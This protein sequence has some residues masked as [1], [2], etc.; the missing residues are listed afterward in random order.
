[1]SRERDNDGRRGLRLADLVRDRLA[2]VVRRELDDP[3]LSLLVVTQVKVSE[4][5]SFVDVG[6]SFLG[7]DDE[8]LRKTLLKRLER[9]AHRLRRALGSELEL[10]KTPELRFHYDPG[11]DAARR[12]DQ[13]LDEIDKE[14]G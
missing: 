9:A 14:R 12:V 3:Q 4:D 6:A 1:M 10:R 5:L 11:Q 7:V 2:T 13:L 8:R